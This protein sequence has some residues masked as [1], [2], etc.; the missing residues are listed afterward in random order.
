MNENEKRIIRAIAANDIKSAQRWALT[1]LKENKTKKNEAFVNK[2]IPMLEE[3]INTVKLPANIQGLLIYENAAESFKEGRYYLTEQNSKIFEEILRI[4][5]VSEKLLKRQIAY[6]NATLLYGPPGTGKTTFGKYVAYKMELPFYYLNFSEIVDS[7]RGET[8]KR[9]ARVFSYISSSRPCVFMIDEIDAVGN[10]RCSGI[11]G[12]T[13]E[14]NRT[15]ITLIQELDKLS[16]DIVLIAATN[17]IDVIDT[18][19]LSRFSSVHGINVLTS[20][21]SR[22][23]VHKFLADVD[24]NIPEERIDEIISCGPDQRSILHELI[25]TIAAVLEQEE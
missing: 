5:R 24:I 20:E 21:E 15:T 22:S 4:A 18:A 25:R 6:K 3:E 17:R 10:M 11:D 19:I 12:A 7:L 13:K 14:E 1:A 8:A 9:M 2:Y 16:N 23:M